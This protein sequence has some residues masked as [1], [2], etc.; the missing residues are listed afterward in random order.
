[1]TKQDYL[2]RYPFASCDSTTWNNPSIYGETHYYRE[3]RLV[4]VRSPKL[5]GKVSFQGKPA[6]FDREYR[7]AESIRAMVQYN[8]FITRLWKARGVQVPEVG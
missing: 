7:L 3:G 8:Q 5:S 1:M 6:I 2:K 4:K